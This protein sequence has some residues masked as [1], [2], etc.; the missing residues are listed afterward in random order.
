MEK[1]TPSTANTWPVV[2]RR[3]PFLMAKCFF[4]PLTS[5][6]GPAAPLSAIRASIE[7]VRAPAGGPMASPF[8]LVG[9][10]VLATAVVGEGATRRERTPGGKVG[11]R[12]NRPRDFLQAGDHVV[13]PHQG[14][15]RNRR[16]QAVRVGGERA[17][18]QLCH[19]RFLDPAP[20]IHHDDALRSLG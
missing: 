3:I 12:R 7:R 11:Q 1:L 16:Q 17:G 13:A 5:S 15:G 18:E 14:E 6:T 9:R 2:R 20:R 10:I 4:S 19:G 8:L